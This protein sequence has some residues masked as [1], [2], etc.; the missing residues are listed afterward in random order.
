MQKNLHQF[1]SEYL[2]LQRKDYI[3]KDF[4]YTSYHAPNTTYTVSDELD[5]ILIKLPPKAYKMWHRTMSNMK[6]N[7]DPIV[8]CTVLFKYE[9]Y[10][11]LMTKN[12]F[13]D[14]KAILL[15]HELFIKTSKSNIIIVNVKY[16]SK[17]FKPKFEFP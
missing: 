13:Y 12:S 15:E 11:D 4:A 9:F 6:R 5:R 17:L 2:E 3:T 14:A 10:K 7:H 8:A 1:I 16:A